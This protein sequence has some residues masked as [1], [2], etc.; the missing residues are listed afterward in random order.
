M[1]KEE[2]EITYIGLGKMG[3]AMCALLLEKG[4][5][6]HG[7][8]SSLDSR[9]TAQSGGV[10]TYEHL[11]D[12]IVAQTGFHKTIW[13]MVPSRYVEEVISDVLP[14]LQQG[15]TL[16]DGGNSFF[17]DSL[18]RHGELEEKGINF[19]DCGTSGGVVGARTGASLMVGGDA[20]AVHTQ[21]SLFTDLATKNG[22]AHV[23]GPSA[24]HFIKMVHNAIEYGMMGAI[25]EGINILNEHKEALSIDVKEALKPY[26]HGSIIESNLMSWLSKAYNT[27]G[28]LER[29]AGGVPKGETEMEME[30]LISSEEVLVLEAAVLQRKMTRTNPSF[31][32]TLIAAMRNQFGG[33]AILPTSENRHL[34]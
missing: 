20:H 9:K 12:A 15:D 32:G 22:F 23:G 28:L 30:Y 13:I 34:Q 29:I 3:G 5:T 31:T 16:I 19:I 11:S 18:R 7:F 2:K 24:G 4:Y 25:A 26:E 1:N 14:Y 6:V 21:T 33:H 27:E 17:K 10:I 8:D